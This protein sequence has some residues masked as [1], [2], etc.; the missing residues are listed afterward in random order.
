MQVK[1][2]QGSPSEKQR[3]EYRE[4]HADTYER[5]KVAFA[6][7][8]CALKRIQAAINSN[9]NNVQ[10]VVLMFAEEELGYKEI[11]RDWNDLAQLMQSFKHYRHAPPI[12]HQPDSWAYGY[13]DQ[14]DLKRVN[15]VHR[16]YYNM[17]KS[18]ELAERI[19]FDRA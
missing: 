7:A 9:I 10:P 1:T 16:R 12:G 11:W 17:M 8:D 15:R 3:K 5:M 19:D 14:N 2:I 4:Y 18:N 6:L 13:L